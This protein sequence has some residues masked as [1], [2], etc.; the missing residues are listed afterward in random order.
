MP[1]INQFKDLYLDYC[2]SIRIAEEVLPTKPR[3]EVFEA[4]QKFV[5]CVGN[6]NG[7]FFSQSSFEGSSL[8]C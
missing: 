5:A 3:E 4:V 6:K 2:S 1:I 8:V 7:Q